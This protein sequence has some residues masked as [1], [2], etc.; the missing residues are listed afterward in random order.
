MTIIAIGSY[1]PGAV[2]SVL[3]IISLK[4]HSVKEVLL[5]IPILQERKLSLTG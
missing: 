4:L 2:L 3:F 5:L 1:V